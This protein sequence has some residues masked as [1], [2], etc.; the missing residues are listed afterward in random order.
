MSAR[1]RID[2][3]SVAVI[4]VGY[5]AGLAAWPRLHGPFLDRRFLPAG[6]SLSASRPRRS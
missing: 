3:R 4:A 1:Q 2:V 6:W 5:F